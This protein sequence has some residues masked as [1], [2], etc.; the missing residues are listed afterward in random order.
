MAIVKTFDLQDFISEFRAYGRMDNFTEDALE[1]IF[2][3]LNESEETIEM[4]VIAICCEFQEMAEEEICQNYDIE[5][6]Q[7]IEDY[8][9]DE[10]SVVGKTENSFVFVQF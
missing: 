5:D 8:L 10:T 9:N 1:I 2:N 4:D 3:H 7:E 6:W